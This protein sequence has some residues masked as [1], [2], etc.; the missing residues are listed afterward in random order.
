M[1]GPTCIYWA[2]LAPF[3]LQALSRM[4][5]VEAGPERATHVILN[6]YDDDHFRNLDALR[7]IRSTGTG[8]VTTRTSHSAPLRAVRVM[9]LTRRAPASPSRSRTSAWTRRPGPSRNA[10]TSSR[11][12]RTVHPGPRGL[13]SALSIF[14]SKLLL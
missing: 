2:N 4:R 9:T 1:H 12:P 8:Q 7:S 3:S 14:H 13:L 11:H 6:I 10:R 5:R